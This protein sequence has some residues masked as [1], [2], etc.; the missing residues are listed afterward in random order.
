MY[1]D[2]LT[3]SAIL[4]SLAVLVAVLVIVHRTRR[5]MREELRRFVSQQEHIRQ[6]A[7]C[8][9]YCVAI[10]KLFP[11]SCPGIDF[12]VQDTD[13]GPRIAQWHMKVPPPRHE[14]IQRTVS[15]AKKAKKS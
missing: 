9:E 4:V 14:E 6:N 8:G 13:E 3:V 1:I 7:D 5:Q 12:L 15:D 11:A 10:C 2:S